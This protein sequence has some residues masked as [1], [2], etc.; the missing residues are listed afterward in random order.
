[1]TDLVYF[2]LGAPGIFITLLLGLILVIFNPY[3]AFLISIFL[4]IALSIKT[5][6][7][8]RIEEV[9]PWFNLADALLIITILAFLMDKRRFL[10]IPA[11]SVVLIAVLV[12]GLMT[13]MLNIGLSYGVVR[14]FRQAVHMPILFFLTANMVQEEARVKSLLLTLVIG[15]GIA[16][17]THLGMVLLTGFGGGGSDLEE[18]RVAY[19]T[20]SNPYIWP[21]AGY[22]VVA[23]GQIP[24]RRLQLA[25]GGIILAATMAYQTRSLA[26]GFLGAVMA[27]YG[28]FLVGP[29]SFKRERFKGLLKLFTVVISVLII[30]GLGGIIRG[31]GGRITQTIDKKQSF[32][33]RGLSSRVFILETQLKDWLGGNPVIGRGLAYFD[34]YRGTGQKRLVDFDAMT[35]IV[36]LSQL[37]LIGFFVY[38]FW[39]PLTV[40]FRARRLLQT[41]GF[42]PAVYYLAAATGACFLMDAFTFI[43]S[44]SYFQRAVVPG[45]LAGAVWGIT[46]TQV[47]KLSQQIP[48]ATDEQPDEIA[49]TPMAAG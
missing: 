14:L 23:A 24:R 1:M 39:Y 48:P 41:P 34:R 31:Y 33:E 20:W 3:R 21:L 6:G 7:Y 26:L 40:I 12:M 22:Y 13:S 37:G 17:L 38:A 5:L 19:I 35:Y 9:G 44:S 15:A 42:S 30:I 25:I 36:Y 45:V 2:T 8:T 27:Y 47:K 16:E 49:K 11:P 29:H 18:T 43:F 4:S 28:W 46:S 32:E 10:M